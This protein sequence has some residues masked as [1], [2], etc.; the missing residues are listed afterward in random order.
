MS[1]VVYDVV[2]DTKMIKL[3]KTMVTVRLL[4]AIKQKKLRKT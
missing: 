3:K 2:Y 4:V 1:A